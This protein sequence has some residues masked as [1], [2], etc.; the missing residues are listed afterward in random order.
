MNS[1]QEVRIFIGLVWFG[2]LEEHREA[3]IL[4]LI[5]V[6]ECRKCMSPG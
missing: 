1:I 3:K 6:K 4:F 2:K 5:N